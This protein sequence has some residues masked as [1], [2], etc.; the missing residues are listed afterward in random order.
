MGLPFWQAY[1]QETIVKG[2]VT[3]VNSGDPIPFANVVFKGTSVGTTT[4]FDGNYLIRTNNPTDTL[5]VSY[6]GYLLKTKPVKKGITQIINFQLDESARPYK[7]WWCMPEKIR[8]STFSE[9]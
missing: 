1:A 7:R 6:V 5:Q 8:P 4:D 3:D 9:K 2:K